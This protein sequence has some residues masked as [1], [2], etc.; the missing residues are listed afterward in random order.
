M[1]KP[2]TT[3]Q[4]RRL[5]EPTL[6][7]AYY[8]LQIDD[9]YIANLRPQ[10]PDLITWDEG[11]AIECDLNQ[12]SISEE[13]FFLMNRYELAFDYRGKQRRLTM[14]YAPVEY[15]DLTERL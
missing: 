1:F 9:T 5:L 14:T 13:Y 10:D 11:D 6:T 3:E 8:H 12:V 4:V 15:I 2:L 7:N